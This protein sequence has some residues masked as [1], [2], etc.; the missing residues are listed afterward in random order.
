MD[1]STRLSVYANKMLTR[2]TMWRVLMARCFEICLCWKDKTSV[3]KQIM[4]LKLVSAQLK[5]KTEK[6]D[7]QAKI[8]KAAL[9]IRQTKK[10]SKNIGE[11]MIYINMGPSQSFAKKKAQEFSSWQRYVIFVSLIGD[12]RYYG[13]LYM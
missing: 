5:K 13:L 3:M 6:E 4:W 7:F 9:F 8:K 1:G 10:N 12:M 2:G 11:M